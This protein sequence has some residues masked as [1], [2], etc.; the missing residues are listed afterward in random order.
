MIFYITLITLSASLFM[1]ARSSRH[2]HAVLAFV[3]GTL[4]SEI[5]LTVE[6]FGEKQCLNC[7]FAY[8]L[9]IPTASI[10]GAIFLFPSQRGFS[11]AFSIIATLS[12]IGTMLL[13]TMAAI[14]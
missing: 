13:A 7:H 11:L 6:I 9:L 8:F 3:L 2:T 14:G 12:Y 4:V 1:I 5:L 10:A